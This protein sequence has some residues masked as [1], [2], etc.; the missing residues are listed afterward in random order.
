MIRAR[1]KRPSLDFPF[2][3]FSPIPYPTLN[4][5]TLP[6]FTFDNFVHS[7]AMDLISH[8]ASIPVAIPMLYHPHPITMR[9]FSPAFMSLIDDT[10]P[11]LWFVSRIS[12]SHCAWSWPVG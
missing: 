8:L 6:N 10:L 3:P 1:R 12:C 9:C 7:L 2:P 11:R 5:I 4:H